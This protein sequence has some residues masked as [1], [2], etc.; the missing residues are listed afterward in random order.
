MR[1]FDS[2]SDLADHLLAEDVNHNDWT[3][4]DSGGLVQMHGVGVR[5]CGDGTVR[6]NGTLHRRDQLEFLERR[7]E[8]VMG[9]YLTR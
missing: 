7:I 5:D 4:F 1:N 9:W 8:S 6:I 2:I 3:L